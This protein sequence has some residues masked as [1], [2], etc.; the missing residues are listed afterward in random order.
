MFVQYISV[1]FIRENIYSVTK[2]PIFDTEDWKKSELRIKKV[3]QIYAN[4]IS[5]YL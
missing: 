4:L 5:A 3:Y 2:N 1:T